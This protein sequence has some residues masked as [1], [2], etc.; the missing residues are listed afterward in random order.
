MEKILA[1]NRRAKFD[2][3]ILDT[4]DAGVELL[5]FEVKSV[6]ASRMSLVGSYAVIRGGEAWLLNA[7]IP[8]Y[9]PNNASQDYDPVRTRRL[10]LR[11]EEIVEL[12]GKTKNKGIVLVPLSAFLHKNFIKI[13]LGICRSKKSHDKREALKKKDMVRARQRGGE[14]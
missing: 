7:Q 8:A 1:D 2:Y 14:E 10:L 12:A 6:K 3:E 9:Q 5:G 4:L 11:H 13:K